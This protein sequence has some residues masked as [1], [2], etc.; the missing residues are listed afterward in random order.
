MSSSHASELRAALTGGGGKV[1]LM[2][3]RAPSG[4]NTYFAYSIAVLAPA[5]AAW[6]TVY[7]TPGIESG[8]GDHWL[9]VATSTVAEITGL[10]F[11]RPNLNRWARENGMENVIVSVED[12]KSESALRRFIAENSVEG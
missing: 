4:P 11:D 6:V 3:R 12:L 5:A 8:G 9:D 10:T 2:G 1:Q 7:T